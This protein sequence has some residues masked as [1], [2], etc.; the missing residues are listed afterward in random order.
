[1]KKASDILLLISGVI[2]IVWGIGYLIAAIVMFV[3]TS[4]QMTQFIINGLNDGTIRSTL[5]GTPEEVAAAIQLVFLV[6]GIV[7]VVALAFSVTCAVFSFTTKNSRSTIGY[8]LVLVFGLLSGTFV[9][10]VGGILGLVSQD[11]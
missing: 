4:P 2:S 9:G 10:T 1:M 3:F 11:E 5:P 8:V 7:M 6:I